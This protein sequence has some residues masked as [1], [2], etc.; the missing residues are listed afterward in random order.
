MIQLAHHGRDGLVKKAVGRR[1]TL[2][3]QHC[4]E[5]SRVGVSVYDLAKEVSP[6]SVQPVKSPVSKPGF[7]TRFWAWAERAALTSTAMR[8]GVFRFI[9]MNF[10]TF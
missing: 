7:V 2:R 6:L 5:R 8:R 9:I 1:T 4:R 10:L 3:G